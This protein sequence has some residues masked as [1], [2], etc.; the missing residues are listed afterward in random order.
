M[1]FLVGISPSN[2]I[3][4]LSSCYGGRTS[5]KFITKD[6]GFYDL[7]QR[8]DVVIANRD[9]YNQKDLLLHF[10]NLQVPP[11]ARAKS[12]MIKKEV[13][14]TKDVSSLR[15]NVERVIS[16]LKNYRILK[17]ALSI[18]MMQHVDEIVLV[19]AALCNI[20]KYANSNQKE[21][22][23]QQVIFLM[24]FLIVF[25]QKLPKDKKLLITLVNF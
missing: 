11:G 3:I 18:T 5:D 19:C 13:Q 10:C 1:K 14:K 17:G 20:K 12:Q 8:D 4:F 23:S 16:S 21:L 6:N 7:L 24:I 9:F 2:F 25:S 22:S 15:I